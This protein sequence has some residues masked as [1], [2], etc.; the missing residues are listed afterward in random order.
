MPESVF[1]SGMPEDGFLKFRRMVSR[2]AG[3]WLPGMPEG[4]S[5]KLLSVYG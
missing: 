1:S 3:I 5:V 2:S 4:V